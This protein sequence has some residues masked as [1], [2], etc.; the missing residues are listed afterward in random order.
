MSD[1]LPPSLDTVIVPRSADL[2]EGMV[3]HRSLPHVQRR[4]VGPFVFFD[5]IGPSRLAPGRAMD[6]RPHPHIGLATVTYLFEGEILH[7]DSLGCVQPIKPGAVNWMTAGRG[8][9]HSERTPMELRGAPD[10]LPYHGAQVWVALPADREEVEPAFHHHPA[11]TLPAFDDGAGVQGRLVLGDLQGLRSPVAVSSPMFQL[12]LR[13]A[14][15][16]RF[17]LPAEHVE[18]AAHLF[19]GSLEVEGH[20]LEAGRLAVFTRGVPV[21]LRAGD[22]GARLIAF[23]GEPLEGP[24]F[25]WWNFVSSRKER[26]EQAKADWQAGRFAAVPGE[27]E[28]IPLPE[29]VAAQPAPPAQQPRPVDYP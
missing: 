2:G 19:E 20:P 28:F 26:I 3:V 9:V 23:G 1:L 4:T 10:G 14:P 15:G 5:A 18:R 24:R 8:I 12:D 21:V 7:R 6:V 17:E 25:V 27:T 13:L 29:K 11:D 22:Q 16:A